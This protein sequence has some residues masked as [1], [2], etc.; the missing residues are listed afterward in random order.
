[1]SGPRVPEDGRRFFDTPRWMDGATALLAAAFC[2][3]F[4]LAAAVG[5]I[6]WA[7]SI[8]NGRSPLARIPAVVGLAGLSVLL[9]LVAK[10]ANRRT[11]D[12]DAP[13]DATTGRLFSVAL[14][15]RDG[16]LRQFLEPMVN[17]WVVLEDDHLRL[18][19]RRPMNQFLAA[20]VVFQLAILG[21]HIGLPVPDS[22]CMAGSI[23]CL[24]LHTWAGSRRHD[25]RFPWARVLSVSTGDH[26]FHVRIDD[27]E[28]PD[29]FL[30]GVPDK[31]HARLIELL[32]QRTLFHD[33]DAAG[34][35]AP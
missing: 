26:R 15:S 2:M 13:T 6:V 31:D 20:A 3:I 7:I 29:G 14:M 5:A 25:L 10:G 17:A 8:A 34:A 21:E 28:W 9:L 27:E 19:F 33:E 23:V 18:C 32:R 22:V 30:F 35:G 24:I 16:W 11:V 1:M 12:S 4:G